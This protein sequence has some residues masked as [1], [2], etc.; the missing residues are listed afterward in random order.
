MHRITSASSTSTTSSDRAPRQRAAPWSAAAVVA[1]L[2]GC[3]GDDDGMASSTSAG[4]GE[5]ASTTAGSGATTT[6]GSGPTSGGSGESTSTA[7]DSTSAGT[8]TTT[9]STAT[10]STATDSTATDSTATDSTATDSSDSTDGTTS[11]STGVVTEGTTM[12][13]VC[14][15]GEVEA[16]YSGPPGTEGVGLCAAGERTCDG[17]GMGFGPCVGEVLPALE[18]CDTPGDDDCD[19][20][21]PCVGDGAHLWSK[22]F[23]SGKSDGED[24]HQVVTDAAGNIFIAASGYGALDFGGGLIG[25]AGLRDGFIAKFAPDGAHLW[26]K[27]IADKESQ[28]SYGAGIAVTPS[29]GLVVAGDFDGT[30]NLGGGSLTAYNYGDVFLVSY[31]GDG[32]HLWSKR[33]QVSEWGAATGVTVDSAGN[34]GVTGW[35]RGQIDLGGGPLVAPVNPFNPDTYVGRFDKDGKHLWSLRFG[36]GGAQEGEAIAADGAGNLYTCGRFQGTI[37]PGKGQMTSAGSTDIYVVRY[38]SVGNAVWAKRFGDAQGQQCHDL[39]VDADG[40][41]IFGGLMQGSVDFGGGPLTNSGTAAY[42]A[43]L[44]LSGGHLWSDAWSGVGS[45]QL[46][47]L[48]IDPVG[49]VAITGSFATS[50]NFG[51]PSLVGE[52]GSDLFIARF[53]TIDV[54]WARQA[55]DFKQQRGD[56]IATDAGAHVITFGTAEGTVN[57]GGG[58]LTSKAGAALVLSKHKP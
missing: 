27:A 14:T 8:A 25:G 47:G 58:P 34:I 23:S 1:L 55:G 16:C 33:L 37:N 36:D 45:R 35:F 2:G 39:K 11:D 32:K 38:D 51:G 46:N 43:A 40:R 52:G 57:L 31:D 50:I 44:D 29:G 26:S 4:S 3:A 6:A 49:N 9:D 7:S 53:S 15:P 18:T 10:D 13:G 54:I 42:I 12:G 5:T 41:V 24:A 56:A 21:N 30:I 48:A 20:Q 28:L 22:I 19:G 17:D